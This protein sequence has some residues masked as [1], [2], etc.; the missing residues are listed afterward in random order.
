MVSISYTDTVISKAEQDCLI[1]VTGIL[2]WCSQ[3]LCVWL[4]FA[5]ERY[6]ESK[7]GHISEISCT[8]LVCFN[9]VTTCLAF[10]HTRTVVSK[11][12]HGLL[13]M[14]TGVS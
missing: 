12:E 13:I 11:S 2:G 1:M 9:V 7:S 10:K 8:C 3:K 4:A 6:L 5:T 14:V